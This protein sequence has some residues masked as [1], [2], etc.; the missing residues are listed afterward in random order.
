MNF[1]AEA[2]IPTKKRQRKSFKNDNGVLV[3]QYS[4]DSQES[5]A[6][7]KREMQE[8]Y[9][10]KRALLLERMKTRELNKYKTDF[11]NDQTYVETHGD[12]DD[13]Q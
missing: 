2:E 4:G 9:A 11:D 10:K 7:R 3:S 1:E 8:A 12:E 5:M 13:A 6:R